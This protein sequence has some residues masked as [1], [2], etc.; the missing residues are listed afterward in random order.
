[1][2]KEEL[3]N[4]PIKMFVDDDNLQKLMM[5]SDDQTLFLIGK[6]INVHFE[7][8]DEVELVWAKIFKTKD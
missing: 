2:E 4:F 1:M 6:N 5:E 3:F 7:G 8:D